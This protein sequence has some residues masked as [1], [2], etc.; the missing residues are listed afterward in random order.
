M[1]DSED[2]PVRHP[3]ELFPPDVH[4]PVVEAYMEGVDRTLLRENLKLT[5]A[6]R[7]GK[8]LDFMEF[9]ERVRASRAATGGS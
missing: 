1:M 8:F 5:P 7:L 3:E 2:G 9:I 4:D 6:E